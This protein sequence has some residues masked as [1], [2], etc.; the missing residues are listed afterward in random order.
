MHFIVSFTQSTRDRLSHHNSILALSSKSLFKVKKI[1]VILCV[2]VA[3][4]VVTRMTLH[5]RLY[6]I[7]CSA[8]GQFLFFARERKRE[9]MEGKALAF[10]FLFSAGCVRTGERTCVTHEMRTRRPKPN[11]VRGEGIFLYVCSM[12]E[13]ETREDEEGREKRILA[14]SRLRTIMLIFFS[15]SLSLRHPLSL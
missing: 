9:K 8:V 13:K 12:K 4:T 7:S 6:E 15:S 5:S 1:C 11:G 14:V 10:P 3:C 2:L